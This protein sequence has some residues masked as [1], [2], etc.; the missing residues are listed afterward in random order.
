S[1]SSTNSRSSAAA[2]SRETSSCRSS[3]AAASRTGTERW[4]SSSAACARRSTGARP[5]TRSSRRATASATGWTRS[6]RSNRSV[7]ARLRA[8]D[9]EEPLGLVLDL[10]RRV[11]DAEAGGEQLLELP[12]NRVAI[13]AGADEHVRRE[14][15]KARGDRPHVQ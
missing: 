14:R 11:V 4:T 2:S 13:V 1:G 9:A 10:Q 7:R 5:G 12:P 3:G 8:P 6:R 15:R